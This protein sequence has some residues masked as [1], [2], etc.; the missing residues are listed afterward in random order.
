[1]C[2]LRT[3]RAEL[4][5]WKGCRKRTTDGSTLALYR[6]IHLNDPFIK[7]PFLKSWSSDAIDI[8]RFLI[9]KH[10]IQIADTYGYRQSEAEALSTDDEDSD[11]ACS[12]GKCRYTFVISKLLL[13]MCKVS[14]FFHIFSHFL[15]LLR[16][17][18]TLY[19]WSIHPNS[20]WYFVTKEGMCRLCTL[21]LNI[22]IL[23]EVW[24]AMAPSAIHHPAPA[25]QFG[26]QKTILTI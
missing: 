21:V 25:I 7:L 1:M 13:S 4:W 17:L 8:V 24:K 22:I 9:L 6:Q 18:D 20:H 12:V 14:H 16:P 26:Q 23:C 10:Y 15:K 5:L 11:D 2:C 3:V 19:C